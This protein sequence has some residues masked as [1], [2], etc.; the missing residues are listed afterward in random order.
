MCAAAPHPTYSNPQST[1]NNNLNNH[2]D[3]LRQS[4]HLRHPDHPDHRPQS[5][6]MAADIV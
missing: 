6:T 5:A 3:Q 4:D 1:Q 2:P